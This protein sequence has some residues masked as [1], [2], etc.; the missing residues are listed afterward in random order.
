MTRDIEHY[1][2]KASLAKLLAEDE[3]GGEREGIGGIEGREG[4]VIPE[5]KPRP[6]ENGQLIVF[7]GNINIFVPSTISSTD[8]QPDKL[9]Q[10]QLKSSHNNNPEFLNYNIG[11]IQQEFFEGHTYFNVN[12]DT[13][14]EKQH[15][16]EEQN[17][18]QSEL[19]VVSPSISGDPT[20]D[21]CDEDS[22]IYSYE[23][24]E[25]YKR[26]KYPKP[27]SYSKPSFS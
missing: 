14:A 20:I 2:L 12:T 15:H 8:Q 21:F 19:G 1:Q 13:V 16:V 23:L 18:N 24:C 10:I 25:F 4:E 27:S 5:L 9:Q 26:I 6:V 3:K 11:N 7:E 17:N 22:E